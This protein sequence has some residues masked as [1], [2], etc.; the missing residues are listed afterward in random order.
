MQ[1]ALTQIV[2][3]FQ[4][5]SGVAA[6][7]FALMTPVFA[8][9]VMTMFDIGLAINER[10]FLD[11]VLRS[12][13][14]L[15]MTGESNIPTLEAAVM[16]AGQGVSE[17][18]DVPSAATVDY[19]LAITRTCECAGVVGLCTERCDSGVAPSLYYNFNASKTMDPVMLPQFD[20]ESKLR[21]Q[22]R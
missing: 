9:C 17:D 12:G 19:T 15:A 22:L 8:L 18:G 20:V 16:N 7:E 6:A 13:A 2:R 4:A 10:M 21:V 3:F 11:K 1:H 14:Q 5:K